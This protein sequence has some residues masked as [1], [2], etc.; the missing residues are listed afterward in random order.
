MLSNAAM[1]DCIR[2]SLPVDVGVRLV[3]VRAH[4]QG[5]ACPAGVPRGRAEGALPKRE[6]CRCEARGLINEIL[7]N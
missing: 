1:L 5:L 7:S 4:G 3:T 2:S 6:R